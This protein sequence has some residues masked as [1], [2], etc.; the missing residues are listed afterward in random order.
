MARE[1]VKDVFSKTFSTFV[2]SH[3]S[4]SSFKDIP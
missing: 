2:K 1:L 4:I 3:I